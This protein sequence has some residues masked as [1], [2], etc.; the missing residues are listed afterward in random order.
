MRLA[1]LGLLVLLGGCYATPPGWNQMQPSPPEVAQ[2]VEALSKDPASAC[3]R[4]TI[5]VGAMAVA[6]I[7]WARSNSQG[8]STVTGGQACSVQHNM[9]GTS[10]AVPQS[11]L[12]LSPLK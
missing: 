4:W 10:I 7:E 1:G 5:T 2:I 12:V 9:V 11:G 6:V 3:F 8:A